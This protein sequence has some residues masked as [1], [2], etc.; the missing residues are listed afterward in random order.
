MKKLISMLVLIV[1][2]MTFAVG[3]NADTDAKT[4][5]Y[6][7]AYDACPIEYH[8]RYMGIAQNI[9]S[10][11][12]VTNDQAD[13]VIA[14]LDEGKAFFSENKGPSLD[15][16]SEEEIQK[17]VELFKEACNIL[18][19]TYDVKVQ[20]NGEHAGDIIVYLYYNSTHIA[21]LDG[22]DIINSS[23][24]SSS[25]GSSSSTTYSVK[26]DTDGGS[27]VV[28][29]R[30]KAN[31]TIEEPE[32]P[33]KEGYIFGGWYSDPECTEEFDFNAT[34]TKNTTLYAKWI[35]V[36]SETEDKPDD[37]KDTDVTEWENPYDDVSESDWYYEAVKFADETGIMNGVGDSNFD[38]NGKLTRGMFVT[39]LYRIEGT[40]NVKTFAD[41]DDVGSG[42]WYEDAVNWAAENGIVNGVSETEFKPND[43]ITREQMAA[44]IARYAQYKG[45]DVVTL[46]ENLHF[47]DANEISEY[48]VP[49][50]N[51][52]VGL[53]II[54][55]YEDGNVGPKDNT[56]RAQAAL[57][58]MRMKE[59]NIF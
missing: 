56:T 34:I 51:W 1:M 33:V 15:A 43:Y 22:D 38:P 31:R 48:A 49:G 39:M 36:E 47:K 27:D 6:D 54:K 7:A 25:S 2:L 53:N 35:P 12:D 23:K 41:F 57:V 21:T 14:L 46:S 17:A 4:K 58:L 29:I 28:K 32:A 44:V 20:A 3:I 9:L 19:I 52:A 10:Q 42:Y 37:G 11:I 5:L 24:P 18:S 50:M 59:N 8:T 16:Y 13:R 40:P 45:L 30:V 26:F 55:G